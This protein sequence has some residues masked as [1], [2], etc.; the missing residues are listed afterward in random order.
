[1]STYAKRPAWVA[2][3][4]LAAAVGVPSATSSCSD[5]QLYTPAPKPV[6]SDTRAV[7]VSGKY[8]TDAPQDFVA[9]VK[10]LLLLDYSQSMIVSDPTTSR[11]QAVYDLMN[12]LGSDSEG[13]KGGGE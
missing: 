6:T 10:I 1:M 4:V 11:A 7:S 3:L 12:S 9:P 5:A 2:L 13:R 8:C